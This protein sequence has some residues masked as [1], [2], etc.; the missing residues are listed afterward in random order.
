MLA[1]VTIGCGEDPGPEVPPVDTIT[2]NPEPNRANASW[3]IDG[4]GGFSQSGTGDL[5]L[6]GMA[7]GDYTVTWETVAGWTTPV[8]AAAM[9]ALAANGALTFTGIYVEDTGGPGEF[10]IM[11]SLD[12]VP[13]AGTQNLLAKFWD[14]GETTMVQFTADDNLGDG[15]ENLTYFSLLVVCP[16]LSGSYPFTSDVNSVFTGGLLGYRYWAV[17]S[18]SLTI[19]T[20][21]GAVCEGSFAFDAV[22]AFSGTPHR[23]TGTFVLPVTGAK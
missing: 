13:W 5:S 8:P 10:A 12:G 20:N 3:Q 23:V 4:P 15:A 18:G 19:S 9:Q 7:V 22:D 17:T 16:T 14:M 1:A 21:N 6:A 11:A 2:I